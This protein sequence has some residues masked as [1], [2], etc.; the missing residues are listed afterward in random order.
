MFNKDTG[1][2]VKEELRMTS[3]LH[4]QVISGTL[5]GTTISIYLVCDQFKYPINIIMFDFLNYCKISVVSF[6][7]LVELAFIENFRI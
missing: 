6:G 2:V 3:Y 4:A 7:M 1:S 5:P